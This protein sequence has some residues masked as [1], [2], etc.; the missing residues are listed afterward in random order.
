LKRRQSKLRL[1]VTACL[2]LYLVLSR[3]RSRRVEGRS[4]TRP[5][6]V[7]RSSVLRDAPS[8]LQDEV[9]V[10]SHQTA[11]HS[12]AT[13]AAKSGNHALFAW[14]RAAADATIPSAEQKG[15]RAGTGRIID[16]NRERTGNTTPPDPILPQSAPWPQSACPSPMDP[17]R[18]RSPGLGDDE[19]A[20]VAEAARVSAPSRAPQERCVGQ[21]SRRGSMEQGDWAMRR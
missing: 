15:F 2:E 7:S 9:V 3:R 10:R 5:T 12:T 11:T 17:L 19:P 4:S 6:G 8:A 13:I 21:Y 14:V 18:P 16:R 20:L 1:G